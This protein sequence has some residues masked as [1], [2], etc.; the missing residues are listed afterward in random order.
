M[1]LRPDLLLHRDARCRAVVLERESDEPCAAAVGGQTAER[2]I[3]SLGGPYDS[4]PV[5]PV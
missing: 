1:T 5:M 3:D 2:N 4:E